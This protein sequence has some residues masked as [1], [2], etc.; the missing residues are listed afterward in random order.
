MP[1]ERDITYYVSQDISVFEDPPSGLKDSLYEYAHTKLI[2][3]DTIAVG[4]C[5]L[6]MLVVET[7]IAIMCR[8][9]T[10]VYINECNEN[11]PP[12]S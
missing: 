4:V 5:E 10:G 6:G 3:H 1:E 8:A 9:F 2:Y 11:S 12:P 7:T